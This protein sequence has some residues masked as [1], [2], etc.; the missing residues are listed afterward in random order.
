MQL[1]ILNIKTNKR[2]EIPLV[3]EDLNDKN[4]QPSNQNND[5]NNSNDS[6][7]NNNDNNAATANETS[8]SQEVNNNCLG[9][10]SIAV[11]P[12]KTLLAVG[13][14]NPVQ[15]TIYEL[16]SFEPVVVFA[17]NINNR[18]NYIYLC[19]FNVHCACA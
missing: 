7:S 12:S 11:N 8:E 19:C 6:N 10:R 14:G 13:A 2:F 16:P 9:I 5:N 1:L 17:V 4:N 15:I 3:T 18:R